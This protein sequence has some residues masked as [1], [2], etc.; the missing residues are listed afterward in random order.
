ML[1]NRVKFTEVLL[2][3]CEIDHE[4]KAERTAPGEKICYFQELKPIFNKFIVPFATRKEPEEMPISLRAFRSRYV[5]HEK[6]NTILE[7]N[8]EGIMEV[9]SSNAHDIGFIIKSAE[10]VLRNIGC[11]VDQRMVQIQF[12]LA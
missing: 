10:K 4:M 8:L 11:Q 7:L 3:V 2:L 9:F 1:L 5:W 12:D 6:V